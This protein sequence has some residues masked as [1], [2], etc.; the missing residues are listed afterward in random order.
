MSKG[1]DDVV[2]PP[3]IVKPGT[4][5]PSK[6]VPSVELVAD[7]CFALVTLLASLADRGIET[8]GA[9]QAIEQR[10]RACVMAAMGRK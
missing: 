9:V 3:P 8:S 6:P 4:P 7:D 5:R 10:L 2:P 1:T